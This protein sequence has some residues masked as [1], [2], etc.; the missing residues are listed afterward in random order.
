MTRVLRAIL[1]SQIATRFESGC[2]IA[3]FIAGDG[4]SGQFYADVNSFDGILPA[5]GTADLGR[6]VTSR[7]TRWMEPVIAHRDRPGQHPA[8]N[9]SSTNTALAGVVRCGLVARDVETRPSSPATAP[10]R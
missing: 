9:D 4:R 8:V 3:T 5:S 1:P 7:R 2:D 10:A 6:D